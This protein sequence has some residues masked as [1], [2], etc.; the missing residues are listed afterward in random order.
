MTTTTNTQLERADHEHWACVSCAVRMCVLHAHC[1]GTVRLKAWQTDQTS[2]NTHKDGLS[3]P[4]LTKH[5][6]KKFQTRTASHS[7]SNKHLC[8]SMFVGECL[9]GAPRPFQQQVKAQKWSISSLQLI[10]ILL[11]DGLFILFVKCQKIPSENSQWKKGWHPL[12]NNPKRSH[13]TVMQYMTKTIT[14]NL[15]S[16][17]VE[18]VSV[19]SW[20][21]TGN[22]LSK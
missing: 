18:P 2:S 9:F 5:P 20:K 22:H 4:N 11:I 14:E 1:R 21:V 12:F 13:F 17:N 7:T 10:M 16:E 6:Q 15:T 3:M 19:F 8:L